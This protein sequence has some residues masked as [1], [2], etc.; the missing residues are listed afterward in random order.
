MVEITTKKV[1]RY[2]YKT[3]LDQLLGSLNL[4]CTPNYLHGH[5]SGCTSAFLNS[6][7]CTNVPTDIAYTSTSSSN[8]SISIGAR[9]L[10]VM[11]LLKNTQEI[12]TC[13]ADQKAAIQK[14]PSSLGQVQVCNVTNLR[15]HMR[16]WLIA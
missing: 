3:Y 2:G 4:G 11:Y 5:L 16:W 8:H 7:C 15:S 1:R 9:N 14:H 6:Y 13:L 10:H 12:S